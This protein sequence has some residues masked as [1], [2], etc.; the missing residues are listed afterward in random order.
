MV[1]GWFGCRRVGLLGLLARRQR[2]ADLA[3]VVF[4]QRYFS[5]ASLR[6]ML[7]DRPTDITSLATVT[8][9]APVLLD[10]DWKAA[11]PTGTDRSTALARRSR[12]RWAEP[13]IP[14]RPAPA[15]VT[16]SPYGQ[17]RV[18]SASLTAGALDPK[19]LAPATMSITSTLG[20]VSVTNC[21]TRTA[22]TFSG[23]TVGG[24]GAAANGTL[25]AVLP[26]GLTVSATLTNVLIL[27]GSGRTLTLVNNAA[28]P[29]PTARFAPGLI[30]V[31]ARPVSCEGYESECQQ[32]VSFHQLPRLRGGR[33]DHHL[34]I[35]SQATSDRQQGADRRLH[36][37]REAECASGTW[38]DVTPRS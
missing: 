38:S 36:Q 14:S 9:T 25:S 17:V 15:L 22:T 28:N 7:S 33:G 4:G 1:D 3:V 34:S 5:M 18:S 23:C 35:S 24:V 11:P 27:A 37:G 20:T 31:N 12:V 2:L 30:W 6:I 29:Q 13:T 32:S 10:G 19:F 21:T 26:S 8:G 16:S